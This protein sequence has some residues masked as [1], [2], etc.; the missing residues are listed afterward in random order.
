MKA[1]FVR[2]K[3]NRML[4]V[5]TMTMSVNYIV[6]LSGS[7]IVGNLVGGEGLAGVNACTPAFG[8]VSFIASILSVGTAMVFSRA[9]GAFDERRAAG[10]FSQSLAFA[11][12][13]G[14]AVF[15]AM[16]LGGEAYL[17][18]TGVTGGVREQAAH[19]WK[20]LSVAMGLLPAVLLMEA[21]VYADGDVAV[22]AA[23]GAVHVAGAVGLSTLFTAVSGDAGGASAG[24]ALIMAAVLA[25]C[26]AH[27]L[28]R[29]NHL[30]WRPRFNLRDLGEIC[31]LSLADS[32][33]YLCWGALM[34]VVNKFTV[35]RFGQTPLPVVAMAASVVEFSIVFDGVGEAIIPIGGMYDGEGN[36][37][38][39]REL[40]RHSAV[41]ATLEGLVCGA[42]FFALAPLLAPLYGI[43]G[44]AAPLL[45]EAVRMTRAISCAMPFM[46]LLMMANT[47]FLVVHRVPFA[48]SVTVVKDFLFPCAGV[49]ILGGA[50][51]IGGIWLGFAAG[52]AAAAAYPFVYVRLRHGAD[53]FPWLIGRDDG[54]SADFTLRMTP[55]AAESAAVRAADFLRRAGVPAAVAGRVAAVVGDSGR[56]AAARNEK[57][58]LVEYFIAA[59][60]DGAR[61]VV[62]DD[63]RRAEPACETDAGGRYLNT[64]GCNRVEYRFPI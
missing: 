62:R 35:V 34:L 11:A 4:A 2:R 41:T 16:Q 32:T 28:R 38:A 5:A 54:R 19:Y 33:I 55:G 3:F 12:A 57:P 51:G 25:V 43:R 46:G 58:P 48:V 37:P 13:A 21:L 9:M 31:A 18:F 36:R 7:V 50:F 24:S 60:K 23:A 17:D 42:A 44:D 29:D 40:A 27:F 53:M 52:Y 8:A 49:L 22:A 30:K 39:L 47:H 63:G 1:S 56:L 14:A 45:P 6:M 64:L 10:V 15:A 61:L 26:C 59:E 20:W